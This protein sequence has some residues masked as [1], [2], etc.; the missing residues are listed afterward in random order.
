MIKL[1]IVCEKVAFIYWYID[2]YIYVNTD[3]DLQNER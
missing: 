3:T 1:V 2:W